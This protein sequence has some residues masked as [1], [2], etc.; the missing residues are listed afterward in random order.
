MHKNVRKKGTRI[1]PNTDTFY[2][3]SDPKWCIVDK[4]KIIFN[5][6]VHI[7][8]YYKGNQYAGWTPKFVVKIATI[9]KMKLLRLIVQPSKKNYSKNW[10]TWVQFLHKYLLYIVII[11]VCSNWYAVTQ[12]TVKCSLLICFPTNWPSITWFLIDLSSDILFFI[13]WSSIL[14]FATSR[15]LPLST[16][17]HMV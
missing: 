4:K 7:W 13:N 6:I 2:E 3:V 15:S 11:H 10:C 16:K 8:I 12:F 1:T 5:L 9:L 17:C 14:W